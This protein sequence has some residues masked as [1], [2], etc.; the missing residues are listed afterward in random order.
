MGA[1]ISPTDTAAG[2]ELFRLAETDKL[3]VWVNVPQEYVTLIKPGQTVYFSVLNYPGRKFAGNVARSAG[4]L[5]TGT[6]TL[7]TELDFE[8]T[9]GALWSGMYGQATFNIHKDHPVLTVPTS[10]LVFDAN[11]TQVAVVGE[12]NKVHFQ[13]IT[14]G[15]DMGTVIEVAT[16]LTTGDRVVSNPGEKMIEGTEVQVSGLDGATGHAADMAQ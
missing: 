9:D 13:P 15:R 2:H 11:G 10:A 1:L 12:N 4:V 7:K 5:D 16:G 3:R 8:N 14:V 6:R